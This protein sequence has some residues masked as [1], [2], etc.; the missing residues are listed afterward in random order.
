MCRTTF[1]TLFEGDLRDAQEILGHHSEAF[2][3]RVY[4]KP[5]AERQRRAVEDL[6]ARLKVVEIKRKAG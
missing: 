1:A 6:D 2:T 5:I 3:L 4:R